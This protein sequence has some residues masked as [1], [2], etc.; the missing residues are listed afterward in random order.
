MT[1]ST[2]RMDAIAAAVT[3]IA[4]VSSQI[5]DSFAEIGDRLSQGHRIFKELEASL[6]VLAQELSGTGIESASQA[7]QNIADRLNDVALALPAEAAL[8][9]DIGEQ[10]KQAGAILKLLSGHIQM[11]TIVAR[12]ARIEAASFDGER[13]S[14]LDFTR[15]AFELGQAAQRSVE[16]CTR[17]GVQLA[18]AVE[19]ALARQREFENLHRSELL[20]VA[21]GLVSARSELKVQQVGGARLTEMAATAASRIASAITEAVMALQSG[22][23]TRQRLEHISQG[24]GRMPQPAPNLML[25]ASAAAAAAAWLIGQLQAEQLKD[26]K[27]AFDQDLARTVS[28]LGAIMC[29]AGGL[30]AQSRAIYGGE[31]EDASSFLAVVKQ[32]LSQAS[33]LIAAC[34]QSGVSVDNAL[35]VVTETVG[36]FREAISGLGDA[37][38]DIILIGM[39]ASLRAAR[40][41]AKGNAFV[42]IANELKAAADQ[43]SAGAHRLRPVLDRIET[44]VGE[45]R[46]RRAKGNAAELARLEP[47]VLNALQ[48]VEAGNEQLVGLMTRLARE[49]AAFDELLGRA[50]DRMTALDQASAALPALAAAIAAQ[51]AA[52]PLPLLS[53]AD[54]SLLGELFTRY[55]ME[56]E[57]EV[58]R[59]VL[60]RFG[61]TSEVTVMP[62]A[63][64][65]DGVLLF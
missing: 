9:G 34:E 46:E 42:V 44:L 43:M 52:P 5:E 22:D 33:N 17:D 55:T 65:D 26:T 3:S 49:S 4:G 27:R 64:E 23:A 7:L 51:N 58:H 61:V 63:H 59:D 38:G 28:A 30:V 29:D 21:A 54:E 45:L 19:A 31:S 36:R 20:S 2:D 14:F 15:E 41:G 37:V 35:S 62:A 10:A 40:A 11:I 48:E 53:A 12:S 32:R 60:R 56:R 47:A 25:E 57:R 24:L 50:R 6:V 39:N 18:K 13:Q 16:A 1:L 8:L